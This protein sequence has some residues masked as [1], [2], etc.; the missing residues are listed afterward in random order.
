MESLKGRLNNPNFLKK[1]PAELV[2][3]EKQIFQDLER[4]MQNMLDKIKEL[5]NL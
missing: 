2:S 4:E 5:D 3:R 1:A